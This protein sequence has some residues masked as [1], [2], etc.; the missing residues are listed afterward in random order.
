LVIFPCGSLW[1]GLILH[2]TTQPLQDIRAV[3]S[4]CILVFLVFTYT[5]TTTLS[6]VLHIWLVAPRLLQLESAEIDW[7]THDMMYFMVSTD[8]LTCPQLT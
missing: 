8:C 6:L 7:A 5:L 4:T 2:L 3:Y 1:A